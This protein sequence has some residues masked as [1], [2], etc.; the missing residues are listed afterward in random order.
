MWS[1]LSA[2]VHQ[3]GCRTIVFRVCSICARQC[4]CGCVVMCP[5]TSWLCCHYRRLVLFYAFQSP[6]LPPFSRGGWLVKVI[7]RRVA[8]PARGCV[9]VLTTID[10]CLTHNVLLMGCVPLG[11]VLRPAPYKPDRTGYCSARYTRDRPPFMRRRYSQSGYC[12]SRHP[13]ACSA[14]RHRGHRQQSD[15]PPTQ[16]CL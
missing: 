2:G 9:A 15:Y 16:C 11:H 1:R 14:P 6:F 10:R 12:Q 5:R 3:A 7:G 8:K 4:G 13:L